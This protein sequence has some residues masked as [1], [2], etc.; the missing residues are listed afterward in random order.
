MLSDIRLALRSLARSPGFVAVAVLISGLGIAAATTMFSAVN[1]LVLRPLA[2]PESNR[3]VAVYENNLPRNVPWFACSYRNYLDWRDRAQSFQSLAAVGGRA[4]NLT[5]DGEPEFVN[6]TTITANFLPTFAV[7]PAVGRNFTIEEDRAGH[8][9]VVILSHAFWQRRFGGRADILQQQLLLDGVPHAIVGVLPPDAFLPVP[10]EIAVPMGL[11][12][13]EED[14]MNHEVSVYGRLSPG[15]EMTAAHTELKTIANHIWDENPGFE[16]GWS[17][18]LV[19]LM[20]DLFAPQVRTA[21]YIL[22]GAVGLLLLI[23]C[24]NLSNLLLVRTGARAHEIAVRTALGAG[25]GR[26]MRQVVTESLLVTL[27]GGALGVL[28]SLW[29]VDLMQT[30]PLPRAREISMDVRVLAA[31]IGLTILTG[32][33]AGLLPA[34]KSSRAN[35][36]QVLQGRSARVAPRSR[37]GNATVVAQLALSLTLLVAATLLG[38]SFVRL[39]Q[40]NPGFT[41]EGALTVAMRPVDSARAAAFYEQLAER[42]RALPGVTAAGTISALPLTEGNTSLNVFPQ[43]DSQL[44]AGESVQAVW[45][46]VD[47]GYFQAMAIPLV[48]GRTFAGLKPDEARRS[49]IISQE[50]ARRLWGEA[51]PIGKQLDPGGNRRFLTVIGVVGDVRSQ[52]LGQAPAPA[53]Y[54]SM[55]R[56]IYGPMHLVVRHQGETAPLA[57]AIRAT[58]KELDPAVPVFRVRPLAEIRAT[59]LEQ[60]KLV[61]GLLAGF[62][63]AALLLATLGTYGVVAASVQQRTTEL[64]IRVAIGAQAGDILRLVLGQGLRLAAYGCGW[65]I[66]GAWAASRLI[67]SLLYATPAHDPL[68]YLAATALLA[69]AA[70]AA[71]F[72]P[73]RRA[74]KVDPMVALRAE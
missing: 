70:L 33:L 30:L 44:A 68:S 40:V 43:G 35:P 20:Q 23:A 32:L 45:R 15:V 67:S 5:G 69:L 12:P 55:H 9:Q 31:G 22:L 2:T 16:R 64:G 25:R 17:T 37:L 27:A 46:L 13:A 4:L 53:F 24:A 39:L 18:H 26:L 66:A 8:N 57:A 6:G 58:V 65:G 62:T 54:W 72:L 48:R 11:N 50:L 19:P 28:A 10:L 61:L 74:T 73:A 29:A 41:A 51:D 14:R 71:A 36:Q 56:F 42:V 59:S 7:V 52:R 63:A 38:R 21:L 49:V 1:A 34:L 47:G 60:E 3:L